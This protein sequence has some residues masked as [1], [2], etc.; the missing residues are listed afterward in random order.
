MER[1]DN[2]RTVHLIPLDDE[3]LPPREQQPDRCSSS[4]VFRGCDDDDDSSSTT[5]S[6]ALSTSSASEAS[7]GLY[8]YHQRQLLQKFC[9][10]ADKVRDSAAAMVCNQALHLNRQLLLVAHQQQQQQRAAV[11]KRPVVSCDSKGVGVKR[12]RVSG[13]GDSS[14]VKQVAL[15]QKAART[16]RMAILLRQMEEMHQELYQEFSNAVAPVESRGTGV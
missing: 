4:H 12:R 2:Q 16:K 11:Q 3:P 10:A 5:T 8:D 9:V 1:R 13:S 15:C 6:D 14:A 7:P